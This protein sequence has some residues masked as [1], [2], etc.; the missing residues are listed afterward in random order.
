M[1]K[2]LP[3]FIGNIMKAVYSLLAP[4]IA[5]DV[6][7]SEQRHRCLCV[8][9]SSSV[10]SRLWIKTERE[11][12][13]N[14]AAWLGAARRSVH[15]AFLTASETPKWA[16]RLWEILGLISNDPDGSLLSK[17]CCW[18]A[19]SFHQTAKCMNSRQDLWHIVCEQWSCFSRYKHCQIQ[20][21]TKIFQN[22]GYFLKLSLE[23]LRTI[24]KN[25]K[26]KWGTWV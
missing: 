19:E 11:A 18:E 6:S 17:Q 8:S 22:L 4:L 5:L 7:D 26:N 1:R 16:S 15:G 10:V 25:C 14:E 2:G 12:S 3:V 9:F 24:K 23:S 21:V 20:W 13:C